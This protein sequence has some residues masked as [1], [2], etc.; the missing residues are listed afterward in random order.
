MH[1]T[2]LAEN[3]Q[4][5]MAQITVKRLRSQTSDAALEL[6]DRESSTQCT[7]SL[8]SLF[9][10]PFGVL[11]VTLDKASPN[12]YK[13]SSPCPAMP[14]QSLEITPVNEAYPGF[15]MPESSTSSPHN[16]AL[17]SSLNEISASRIGALI[18]SS[19]NQEEGS[20]SYPHSLNNS[21]HPSLSF[22]PFTPPGPYV[23][24]ERAPQL[25]RYFKDQ[26]DSLSFPLKG[27]RKCPWRTIHL[28]RAEKAYAELLLH[29]TA[30]N[31]GLSLFYSLLAASCLHMSSRNDNTLDWDQYG[32]QYKQISR[33]HL[34]LSI[35]EE[36]ASDTHVKYKELLIALLSTIML[37]VPSTEIFACLWQF[38]LIFM[39]PDHL[40]KL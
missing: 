2:I 31:T 3:E 10:G 36:M 32:K 23:I 9:Q 16:H 33:H 14:W 4:E 15:W 39:Y 40:W 17:V 37:E 6:L 12:R 28:P 30:S 34:E 21:P 7:S 11:N 27:N 13:K 26:I 25:L 38:Q 1:L 24:T 29:Q 22:T 19:N 8:Q 5:M 20:S 18:H 35:Q